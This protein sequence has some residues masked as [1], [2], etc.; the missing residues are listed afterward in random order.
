MPRKLKLYGHVTRTV[1]YGTVHG[2]SSGGTQ[3][4]RWEN[5]VPDLTDL[6]LSNSETGRKQR[7]GVNLMD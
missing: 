6:K 4:R 7:N 1:E 2:S 3:R 5:D